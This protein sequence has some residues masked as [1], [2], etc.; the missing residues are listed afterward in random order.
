MRENYSKND[1]SINDIAGHVGISVSQ[2]DK[3]M[4][5]ETSQTAVKW[6]TIIRVDRA[7]QLLAQNKKPTQIYSE[8]GYANISYFS[9]VFKSVCGVSPAEYRR[10]VVEK[11]LHT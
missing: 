2:L 1:L 5:K 8:V 7:K 4:K 3:L 11:K 6:L 9:N 10:D